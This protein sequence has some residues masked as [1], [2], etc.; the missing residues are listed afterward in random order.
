VDEIPVL[1]L[2]ENFLLPMSLQSKVSVLRR[3]LTRV[4]NED[5]GACGGVG[6]MLISDWCEESWD[7]L[8]VPMFLRA[9]PAL[10]TFLNILQ[11]E[12]IQ[13]KAHGEM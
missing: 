8:L 1:Q 10:F 7:E 6:S 11:K 4:P 3:T 13:T 9:L 2:L 12:S 5:D